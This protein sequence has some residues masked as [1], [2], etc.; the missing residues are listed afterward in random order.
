MLEVVPF[1]IL[2]R[3]NRLVF[4]CLLVCLLLLLHLGGPFIL[5]IGREHAAVLATAL[6]VLQ[7]ALVLPVGVLAG[8]SCLDHLSPDAGPFDYPWLHG[9]LL[10]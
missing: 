6:A 2:P 7:R 10:S 3:L 8:Y 1:V 4:A 5:P 9:A